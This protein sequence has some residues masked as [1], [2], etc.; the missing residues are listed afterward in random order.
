MKPYSAWLS[1]KR[2]KTIAQLLFTILGSVFIVANTTPVQAQSVIGVS[3][4]VYPNPATVDTYSAT[5]LD[6]Y[7]NYY[8]D[9]YVEGY[10]YQKPQP[11]LPW[12]EIRSGSA[13]SGSSSNTADGYMQAPLTVPSTYQ[14]KSDHYL[15]AYY[16]YYDEYLGTWSYWNPYGYGFASTGNPSGYTFP[17]GSAPTSVEQQYIYLGT[18]VVFYPVIPNLTITAFSS[19]ME[20]GSRQ[21][22]VKFENLPFSDLATVLIDLAVGTE[23]NAT[24]DSGSFVAYVGNGTSMLPIKGV[25]KSQYVDDLRVRLSYRDASTQELFSVVK[26]NLKTVSFSGTSYR[27]VIK[28]T[29]E[30]HEAYNAPHWKVTSGGMPEQKSPACYVRNTKMKISAEWS[31]SPD[32][33]IDFPTPKVKG[34]GNGN[35]DFPETSATINAGSS[36][37]SISISD[38]EATNPFA[39]TIDYIDPL[40]ID[41][42][43]SSQPP[44]GNSIWNNSGASENP[45]YVL[46]NDPPAT[47]NIFSQ[48]L[49]LRLKDAL[50][51]VS[52]KNAKGLADLT[53]AD[54]DLIVTQ[55]W[56]DFTDQQIKTR[57]NRSLY[58][59]NSFRIGITYPYAFPTSLGTILR[60]LIEEGDGQCSSWANFLAACLRVQGLPHS[61][62]HVWVRPDN[63]DDRGFSVKNWSFGPTQRGTSSYPYRNLFR[64]S[65]R[66]VTG[67]EYMGNT[68]YFWIP[69][70]DDAQDQVGVDGQG[71]NSNPAS[72]FNNHQFLQITS[73]AGGGI[74][75]Y[76]PSYGLTYTSI[77]HFENIA[78]DGLW[79]MTFP[80][81]NEQVENL[82]L[83]GFNGITFTYVQVGAMSFRLNPTGPHVSIYRTDVIQ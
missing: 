28:D 60:G 55:I 4:I 26:L 35:L 34:D 47:I 12:V 66:T 22:E 67:Q 72:L 51:Y 82:D 81:L 23:G 78:I 43:A 33:T 63:P 10:L 29:S 21:I 18:T 49:P 50:L 15:V 32:T 75:Y 79:N 59:Y 42:Q 54:K 64:L 41:W 53:P 61:I 13:Y 37:N 68:F 24:F 40:R 2:A 69:T 77:Q 27:P 74:S 19:V 83:N 80:S 45:I 7:A 76:D 9:A 1:Y 48:T 25:T 16:S 39:N 36:G 38:V 8:Y 11:Y 5:Q 57:E 71:K 14:L 3:A 6:Y 62:N 44:S 46:L 30:T 65:G 70:S 20:G 73:Q 58:Y 52:C 56:S 17:F 31:P